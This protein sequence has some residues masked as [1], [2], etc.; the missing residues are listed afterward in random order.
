MGELRNGNVEVAHRLSASDKTAFIVGLLVIGGL[1]LLILFGPRHMVYDE[2]Y[3][4]A[5]VWGV[6]NAGWIATL[7]SETNR[8]VVGPLYTVVHLVSAPLTKLSPPAFRYPN[9]VFFVGFVWMLVLIGQNLGIRDS[10]AAAVATLGVPFVWAPVGVALTEVPAL[11]CATASIWAITR[12]ECDDGEQTTLQRTSSA[13]VAGIFLGLACLGRQTYLVLVPVLMTL[14]RRPRGTMV[15]A[16]LPAAIACA[17]CGWLFFVWKGLVPPNARALGVGIKWDYAI[18]SFG[19]IA[20]ATLFINPRWLYASETGKGKQIVLAW[21]AV[22]I[23]ALVALA[24]PFMTITPA[25]SLI[26]SLASAASVNWYSRF[27]SAALVALATL[28]IVRFAEHFWLARRDRVWLFIFSALFLLAITPA[29][30]SHQFSSRYV[31]TSLGLLTL[32]VWR[33]PPAVGTWYVARLTLGAVLGALILRT[34]YA[35]FSFA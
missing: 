9:L 6:R 2:S 12:A 11:F 22:A 33:R 7:T 1:F 4:I 25:R 17:V 16:A 21:V 18:L 8:S 35:Q 24:F 3:H 29:K 10:L 13:A 15:T 14:W 34:Y 5:N 32:V 31:V 20:L 19:Y 26:T 23:I 27:V 30:I 28:W